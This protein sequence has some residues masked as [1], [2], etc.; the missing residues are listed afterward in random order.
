M[1]KLR[2]LL[3]KRSKL[4]D[5]LEQFASELEDVEG[6]YSE[7]IIAN[8]YDKTQRKIEKVDRKLEKA[9]NP[10]DQ[11]KEEWR[12]DAEDLKALHTNLDNAG[13]QRYDSAGSEELS[14]WGRV[15]RYKHG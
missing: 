12:H 4:R 3:K 2:K 14:I 5:V 11:Q 9:S 10:F 15:L 8:E 1:A 6:S 7:H 13:V